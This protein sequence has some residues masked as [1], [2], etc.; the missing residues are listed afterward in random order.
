ML[1]ATVRG[2]KFDFNNL[3][4]D[5]LRIEDIAHALNNICRFG[6]HCPQFYSVAQHSVLMSMLATDAGMSKRDQRTALMHDAS[7]AY[8][9][10]VIRHIKSA[11]PF[12][13]DMEHK[14]MLALAEKFDFDWPMP[15]AIKKLDGDLLETEM[16]SLWDGCD[17]SWRPKYGQP[18]PML[19]VPWSRSVNGASIFLQAWRHLS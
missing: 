13:A 19:V 8:L 15:P 1:L 9:G 12:Y 6:G 10:D 7:E 18:L 3:T 14:M 4:P 17:L 11:I 5:D 2:H 16:Q